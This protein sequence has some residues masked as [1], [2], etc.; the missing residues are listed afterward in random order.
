MKKSTIVFFIFFIL[1]IIYSVIFFRPGITILFAAV[2][3]GYIILL[4]KKGFN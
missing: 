2:F 1:A 3:L 4:L